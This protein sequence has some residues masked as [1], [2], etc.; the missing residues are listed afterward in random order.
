MIDRRRLDELT[1]LASTGDDDIVAQVGWEIGL[2]L[3]DRMD[4]L[5]AWVDEKI[6]TMA[7][8]T[9]AVPE[10][11]DIDELAEDAGF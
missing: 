3:D 7:F 5:D 4:E 1:E 6:G 2:A 8:Q 10:T 11:A 9:A